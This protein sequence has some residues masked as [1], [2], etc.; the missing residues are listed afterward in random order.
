MNRAPFRPANLQEN[1][2]NADLKNFVHPFVLVIV[3]TLFAVLTVAFLTMPFT[4]GTHPGDPQ[5]GQP[6]AL[7][8]MT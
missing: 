7:R 6:A 2:M 5:T 1:T 8:H 3:A 4:L